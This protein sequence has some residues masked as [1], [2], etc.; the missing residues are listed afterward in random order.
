MKKPS[1]IDRV[2]YRIAT[3]H[4]L[5]PRSWQFF[6]EAV[7]ITRNRAWQP[8]RASDADRTD[9]PWERIVCLSHSRRLAANY[10]FVKGILRDLELF[11][12]GPHGL[13]C[14]SLSKNTAWAKE[15][16][17]WFKQWAK[18][19]DITSR[20]NLTDFQRMSVSSMARDGDHGIYKIRTENNYP[21]ISFIEGHQ[22]GN[23]LGLQPPE[24]DAPNLIDGVFVNK[25]GMPYKYRLVF[26]ET[27][28]GNIQEVSAR[29]FL[30]VFEPDRS[31]GHRGMPWFSNVLN[32]M[33]DNEDLFLYLKLQAKF[34]AHLIGWTE[35]EGGAW[36]ENAWDA[37]AN[38][39]DGADYNTAAFPNVSYDVL[40][41]A[42]L[43]HAKMGEKLNINR[44]ERPSDQVMK[45]IDKLE[46]DC[47]E[48]VGLT[49]SWKSLFKEGGATLRAA[50]IRNQYRFQEIQ[51]IE[52][53]G[54][55]KPVRNWAIACAATPKSRGG[56][57][58]IGPV[59]DDWWHH[60]WKGPPL[61]TADVAKVNKENREDIL[62]GIRTPQQDAAEEG[63]DYYE[64]QNEIYDA[65]EY[66]CN[67]A[68]Q[69]S[70]K[71]KWL[72]PSDAMHLL[73]KRDINRQTTTEAET[74]PA[75]KVKGQTD[76]PAEEPGKNR[77][78]NGSGNRS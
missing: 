72:A 58:E 21:K 19:C 9:V 62:C 71:H 32:T 39:Q 63:R 76:E 22:I 73:Q 26:G 3:G 50:L 67:Q 49:A 37:Q 29:D 45:L 70:N 61:L 74:I 66:R 34:D 75:D 2:R 38:A 48:S 10:G 18:I 59:P 43:Y 77:L 54:F 42:D 40:L 5:T 78:K 25:L 20:F 52:E 16:D 57:G 28:E 51:K 69:L 36:P 33:R 11:S 44:S 46:G 1:L 15:A 41:G 30:H 7:N 31:T 8:I 65:T 35:T 13:R 17:D 6:R 56:L 55:L 4:K 68:E 47:L 23:G 53:N 12:L 27:S 24:A 14:K 60:E 64:G